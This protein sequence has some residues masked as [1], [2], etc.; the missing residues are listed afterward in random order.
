MLRPQ[1]F[2]PPVTLPVTLP[3]AK[4]AARVDTEDDTENGFLNSLIASATAM[5]D[6]RTGTLG[7]C[8]IEQTWRYPLRALSPCLQFYMPDGLAVA[9]STVDALGIESP[10]DATLFALREGISGA[11]VIYSGPS[12]GS[13]PSPVVGLFADVTFGYGQAN[14][15]PQPIRHAI[16]M[17]VA[18]WFENREAAQPDRLTDIPFGVDRILSQYRWRT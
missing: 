16:L 8:L 3:E 15:V 7:R 4:A 2:V 13:G 10:I 1:L 17:L 12:V 11:Q 9:V 18:H 14:D 6:G 5:M